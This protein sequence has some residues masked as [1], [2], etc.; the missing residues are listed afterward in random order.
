MHTA[1]RNGS[2][3][4]A[5]VAVPQ[6]FSSRA[7]YLKIVLDLSTDELSYNEKKITLNKQLSR[8][9][10]YLAQYP[11]TMV[12][13]DMLLEE[14]WRKR[15][16]IVSD[17]AVRQTIFRLRRLL[18]ELGVQ[19]NIIIS[20]GKAGYQIAEGK[21]QL[22]S[23]P[24]IITGED[25]NT[26]QPENKTSDAASSPPGEDSQDSV[27]NTGTRTMKLSVGFMAGVILTSLV[28]FSA[29]ALLR[30]NIFIDTVS[31]TAFSTHNGRTYFSHHPPTFSIP[32]KIE[33]IE[34]RLSEN[35]ILVSRS[36]YVY[37][38]NSSERLL[39]LFVCDVPLEKS[40]NHCIN[41]TV[42]RSEK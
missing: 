20:V 6:R 40:D 18:Q 1:G 3:L 35:N 27:V 36:R 39:N 28:C 12:T 25:R 11:G 5:T 10:V 38:N 2:V 42:I 13:K 19:E 29:T 31:Y 7:C 37:L 26:S 33:Q 4:Y 9:L 14:C 8:C 23:E 30:L 16:V 32:V 41:F 17:N 15:G 22:I 21:I 24:A 34:S